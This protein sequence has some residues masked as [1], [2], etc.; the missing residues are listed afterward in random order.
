MP[1]CRFSEDVDLSLP[2]AIVPSLEEVTFTAEMGGTARKRATEHLGQA[3][4][5]WAK[6]EASG[7]LRERVM[8][9]LPAALRAGVDL[10]AVEPPADGEPGT[11]LV[12]F[13]RVLE[14]RLYD[15][16]RYMKQE[17]KLEFGARSPTSPWEMAAVAPYCAPVTDQ[18]SPAWETTVRVLTLE[19]TF[20]E[21]ATA[22]HSLNQRGLQERAEGQSRH[23]ADLAQ[24]AHLPRGVAAARDLAA[25]QQVADD[26]ARLYHSASSRYD[27][28]RRGE[29]MLVPRPE[30]I[31]W[32]RRDY[33]LTKQMYFRD[34]QP[35]EEMLA[36]LTDLSRRVATMAAP[37]PSE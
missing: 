22:V 20:W 30:D 31:A 26:K 17:V 33:E 15:Q 4:I 13:P 29:L 8:E 28:A 19:R 9:S 7:G 25:L 18:R 5:A 14:Q 6:A 27:L 3:L 10:T 36:T 34:P 16:A 32:L 24:L 23:F 11:I 37:L 1:G 21:K 35:L 12:S 2:P